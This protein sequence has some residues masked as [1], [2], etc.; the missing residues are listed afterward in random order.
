MS[1]LLKTAV[2]AATGT[3]P[4]VVRAHAL[5]QVT[6]YT[7][8]VNRAA[9]DPNASTVDAHLERAAYWAC[10]A[11]ENGASEEEISAARQEGHTTA[12]QQHPK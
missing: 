4:S 10:T 9:G 6:A 11:R 7:R 8:E 5:A 12:A 2:K 1:T 3:V